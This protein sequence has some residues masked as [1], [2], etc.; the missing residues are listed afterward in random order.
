MPKALPGHC[1]ENLE[2]HSK[3]HVV[4]LS[5]PSIQLQQQLATHKKE[6]RF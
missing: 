1:L 4:N 5:M 6:A 2:I 3:A